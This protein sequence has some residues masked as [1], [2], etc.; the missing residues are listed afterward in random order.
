MVLILDRYYA[1]LLL[2]DMGPN[3]RGHAAVFEEALR[4]WLDRQH[5]KFH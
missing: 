1:V 2:Y 5:F 3:N 4:Q